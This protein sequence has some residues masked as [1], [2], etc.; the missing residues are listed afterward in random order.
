MQLFI[1]AGGLGT[2][3]RKVVNNVPKPMAR[4]NNHPFLTYVLKYWIKQ[5]VKSFV[6]SVGYLASIIK[7]YYGDNFDGHP[8]FYLEETTPLGTGGA[9]LSFIEK[10]NPKSNFIMINGDSFFEI[11]L[12]SLKNFHNRL[13]ALLTISAFQ[14]DETKRYAPID[15][16]SYGRVKN[17]G[18]VKI[19]K[20]KKIIC[21]GGVYIIDPK[22]YYFLK[23]YHN[24]KCS[25]ETDLMNTL[26]INSNAVFVK[27]FENRF[28]DIGIPKDYKLAEDF[29]KQR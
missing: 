4:V 2:R 13:D 22:I 7:D 18:I 16:D 28:L 17:F 12:N 1:L 11:N 19:N 21:N 27:L 29:F 6:I 3:L 20:D 9:L 23:K 14:S 5:G 8:I 25:F 10:I 26:I 24:Q 15:F